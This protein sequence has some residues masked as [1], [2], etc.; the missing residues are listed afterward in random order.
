MIPNTDINCGKCATPIYSDC[1]MW[2]GQNLACVTV[3]QDCCDT[4]LTKV[5]ELL[6]DYVCN[7]GSGLTWA[8]VTS[9]ATTSTSDTFQAII[10][11]INT[12]SIEYSTSYFSVTNTGSCPS[13]SL[14]VKQ[15]TWV[16]ITG[17]T[18]Y[19]GF[20]AYSTLQYMIEPATNT[21]KLRGLLAR[22]AMVSMTGVTYAA[23]G[24]GIVVCDIPISQIIPSFT[25]IFSLPGFNNTYLYSQGSQPTQYYNL[26]W[27]VTISSN[28]SG[29]LRISA[30]VPYGA[31]LDGG[32]I[33]SGNDGKVSFYLD[34]VYYTL[35]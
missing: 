6:G 20:S 2:S 9:G 27:N 24:V 21:V 19:S 3:L 5:V 17:A 15:G 11:A 10:N 12:Q 35:N 13:K 18:F 22:N 31:T 25:P 8:C 23:S 14:A 29:G 16:T 30:Y 33:R 4:S 1:V 26:S 28:V 32:S 7:M 34:S